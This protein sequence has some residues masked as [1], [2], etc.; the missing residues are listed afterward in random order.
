[1]LRKSEKVGLNRGYLLGVVLNAYVSSLFSDPFMIDITITQLQALFEMFTSE[2]S[3]L[4]SLNAGMRLYEEADDLNP[5]KCWECRLT[6]DEYSTLFLNIRAVRK[7][8]NR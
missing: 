7:V 3:Y 6:K 2:A 8:S 5:S 4:K 1:M